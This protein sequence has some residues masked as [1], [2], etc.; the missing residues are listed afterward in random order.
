MGLERFNLTQHLYSD[1]Y[2]P[3]TEKI[4]L[5]FMQMG[6]NCTFMTSKNLKTF[7]DFEH[8]YNPTL[9]QVLEKAR[10]DKG[11]TR[12]K[13]A[14]LANINSSSL[15]K[16]E[17]AGSRDGKYPPLPKLANLCFVLDIDPRIV[18]DCNGVLEDELKVIDIEDVDIGDSEL[19]QQE[20][21]FSFVSK[22]KTKIDNLLDWKLE[23]SDF[24]ELNRNLR[25]LNFGIHNKLTVQMHAMI[26]MFAKAFD[27]DLEK[28][29]SKAYH[30]IKQQDE[31]AP[32]KNGP[33]VEAPDR[34]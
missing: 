30:E 5:T 2:F 21:K 20:K 15:A 34:S 9:G 17:K 23:I 6:N 1:N 32:I 11:Y 8:L 10:R 24:E 27:Q 18:F 16:W 7:K 19:Y 28:V 31:I 4:T 14:E 22:Y 13:L 33:D 26:S 3:Y 12:L 25:G 29:F